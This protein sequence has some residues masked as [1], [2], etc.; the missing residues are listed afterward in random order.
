MTV[1]TAIANFFRARAA[2][3]EAERRLGRFER[4]VADQRVAVEASR[5]LDE[6]AVADLL[7]VIEP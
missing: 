4:A 6:R 1:T 3:R 5:A 7:R 2:L